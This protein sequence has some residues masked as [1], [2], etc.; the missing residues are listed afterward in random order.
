LKEV[1]TDIFKTV[2]NK[3]VLNSRAS[4]S[5]QVLSAKSKVLSSKRFGLHHLL[6]DSE[7]KELEL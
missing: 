7:L 6:D 2:V 5:N 3:A 4:K 1:E